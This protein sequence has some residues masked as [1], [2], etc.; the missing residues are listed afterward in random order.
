M[1]SN[2]TALKQR[3]EAYYVKLLL[4]LSRR[5]VGSALWLFARLQFV[6]LWDT[7]RCVFLCLLG[8]GPRLPIKQEHWK[9]FLR[10]RIVKDQ[11]REGRHKRVAHHCS[12]SGRHR[13][14][15]HHYSCL[16]KAWQAA[17]YSGSAV[18]VSVLHWPNVSELKKGSCGARMFAVLLNW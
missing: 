1:Q 17:H 5:D 14:H 2:T 9:N 4:T 8:S 12:V 6:N 16:D 13:R 18:P 7:I 3:L 10:D 15:L 11:D